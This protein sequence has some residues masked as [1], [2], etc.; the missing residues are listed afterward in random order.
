M[1]ALPDPWRRLSSELAALKSLV[2]DM[3]RR[4]PFYGSGMELDGVGGVQSD[5]FDGDLAAGNAGTTGWAMNAVRAAFGELILRPG[6]IGNDSLTDPVVPGV[7]NLSANNFSSDFP[8]FDA[9]STSLTVPA[10]CTRLLLTASAWTQINNAKTTG[11]ADGLGSD[12]IYT[13][14]TVGATTGQHTSTGV[15]GNSGTATASSG[16]AAL[17]T[18]LTP[19]STLTLAGQA[20]TD[21]TNV[22]STLNKAVLV[23]TLSWLR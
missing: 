12:Y 17:L 14:V 2:A 15:S 22:A 8:W 20:S 21:Y 3:R 1:G 16:L 13:R 18:G 6:S 11:G 10:G 4:S 7:V 19:G 5:D 9:V 23:A